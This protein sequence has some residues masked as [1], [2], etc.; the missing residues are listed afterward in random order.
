VRPIAIAAAAPSRRI[1]ALAV[2]GVLALA[3]VAA[4]SGPSHAQ[5]ATVTTSSGDLGTRLVDSTGLT[6]YYF[7]PD[8]PGASVCTGDCLEMWP[9]LLASDG[10]APGSDD[11]ITGTLAFTTREDA[12]QQATY[13][14]RPLYYYE[15][16]QAPGDT[17]GQGLGDVWF[18]AAEDGSIPNP[19]TVSSPELVLET[20]S[21]DLGNFITGIDGRTAYF[22]SP[23]VDPGVSACAGD[24]L[25]AWPPVTVSDGISVAAADGIPGVIGV[26]IATDGSPQVTYDGRPLYY[27][28][29]DAVAGDV[30]GQG[31]N[32]IWWVATIDGQLPD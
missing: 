27:Y 23:D 9:P 26:I 21:T 28:A 24:C 12:T 30:N 2:A 20:S 14:G 11:T 15:G 7:T 31:F 8:S 29:G 4:I 1:T 6:L 32:D 18:V 25:T 17:N 22:F 10:I 3:S 13:R 16:D 5:D 19:Q